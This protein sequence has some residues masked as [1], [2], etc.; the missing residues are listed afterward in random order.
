MQGILSGGRP[1]QPQQPQ[2]KTVE[3]TQEQYDVVAGQA[4]TYLYS[5]PGMQALQ[6]NLSTQDPAAGMANM[7]GRLMVMSA[8]SATLA[9][10]K[11]PP[12]VLFQ[13]GMEV[14]R[15][16]SELGQKQGV[17]T[18]ENEKQMTEDA[19]YNGVTLFAQEAGEEALTPSDR[20]QYAQLLDLL[21][22][23]ESKAAGG[24]QQQPSQGQAQQQPMQN[25]AQQQMPQGVR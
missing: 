16:M 20:E 1:P 17:L 18:K 14:A 19:F 13:A 3:G 9:G 7:L 2:T 22:Q 15:A 11:I 24:A 4:L 10:K 8:Q 5:K 6:T 21:E 25:N 23:M 12:K